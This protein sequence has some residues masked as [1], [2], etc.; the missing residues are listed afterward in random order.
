VPLGGAADKSVLDPVPP[1]LVERSR[2]DGLFGL[3]GRL[4]YL[5]GERSRSLLGIAHPGGGLARVDQMKR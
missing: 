4:S 2:E 5:A 3:I 1:G